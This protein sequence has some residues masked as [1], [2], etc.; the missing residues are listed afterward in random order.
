M[1]CVSEAYYARAVCGEASS[2][3]NR[4]SPSRLEE[5]GLGGGQHPGQATVWP[6]QAGTNR[7]LLGEGACSRTGHHKKLMIWQDS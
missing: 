4:R 2:N 7:M 3:N 1:C 5:R 6:R